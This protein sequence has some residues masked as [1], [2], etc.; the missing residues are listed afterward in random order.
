MSLPKEHEI[1]VAKLYEANT[2]QQ[3][4]FIQIACVLHVDSSSDR[5]T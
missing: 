1:L 3:F 5:D 2:A 4:K